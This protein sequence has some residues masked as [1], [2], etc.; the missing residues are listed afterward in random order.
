MTKRKQELSKL[1]PLPILPTE[2]IYIGVDIGKFK[3]VAGFVSK[4]LLERHKHFEN[5]PAFTFE[6]SREGF[7][8]LVERIRAYGPLEHCFLLLVM[9]NQKSIPFASFFAANHSSLPSWWHV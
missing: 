3:H 6:Q 9:Y 4:T 1:T 2:A 7:R 8:A 5:C